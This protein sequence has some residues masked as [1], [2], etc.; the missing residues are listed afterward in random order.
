MSGARCT[1]GSCIFLCSHAFP[2]QFCL[3]LCLFPLDAACVLPV[4][5]HFFVYMSHQ[6]PVPLSFFSLLSILVFSYILVFWIWYVPEFSTSSWKNVF[7]HF[8]TSWSI[9]QPFTSFKCCLFLWTVPAISHTIYEPFP[10]LFFFTT[11]MQNLYSK[12]WLP[13]AFPWGY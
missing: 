12:S 3:V 2:L 11:H 13:V 10:V 6:L 1:S 7:S 9:H 5:I 4:S 8:L